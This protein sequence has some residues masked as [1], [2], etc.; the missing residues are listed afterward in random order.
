MTSG[1]GR[2]QKWA[3][4]GPSGAS[5]HGRGAHPHGGSAS[6]YFR[7]QTS[8]K[9]I[10][11]FD[12]DPPEHVDA[13]LAEFASQSW[14]RLCSLLESRLEFVATAPVSIKPH[15]LDGIRLFTR[16]DPIVSVAMAEATPT[17]GLARRRPRAASTSSSSSEDEEEAEARRKVLAQ[18]AV[19]AD[20]IFRGAAAASA[21]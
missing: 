21:S 3:P 4:R 13:E 15:A 16:S 9:R 5:P 18:L 14:D 8:S 10:G 12:Q 6:S 11:A 20:D 1:G 19:S 7:S 17:A 2:H